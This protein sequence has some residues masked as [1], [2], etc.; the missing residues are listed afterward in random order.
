MEA[1]NEKVGKERDIEKR[2]REYLAANSQKKAILITARAHP[3]EMQASFALE[4]MVNYL[5]SNVLE[6]KALRDKYIIY[7]IPMLNIDGVVFGN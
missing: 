5:V 2:Y 7:V 4:G 6:A 1:G 3:G